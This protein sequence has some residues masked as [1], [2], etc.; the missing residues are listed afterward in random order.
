MDDGRIH[1]EYAYSNQRF[2]DLVLYSRAMTGDAQ[3][4]ALMADGLA[5][6][7]MHL[8]E[9]LNLLVCAGAHDRKST[10]I[11]KL[12][13]RTS[14]TLEELCRRF[15]INP[16]EL[17]CLEEGTMIS[18]FGLWLITSSPEIIEAIKGAIES[19]PE[20]FQRENRM[21]VAVGDN[22]TFGLVQRESSARM[23][24]EPARGSGVAH[25]PASRPDPRD[26]GIRSFPAID[27]DQIGSGGR[28]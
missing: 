23:D 22:G 2:A 10:E 6:E 26:E 16:S 15:E 19:D 27:V 7:V 8:Y 3:A 20:S 13:F 4:L 18:P 17:E 12:R 24:R 25:S 5:L 9:S 1:V 21:R 11:M 14:L 28:F